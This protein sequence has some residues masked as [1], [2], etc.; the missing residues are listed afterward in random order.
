VTP[1]QGPD[2]R[3]AS[4][5]RSNASASRP[6]PAAVPARSAGFVNAIVRTSDTQDNWRKR[7]RA[8]RGHGMMATG[9]E[10]A[11]GPR[12]SRATGNVARLTQEQWNAL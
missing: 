2:G 12:S 4:R 3:V 1:S 5:V 11:A 8:G 10:H 7:R 9:A 6:P